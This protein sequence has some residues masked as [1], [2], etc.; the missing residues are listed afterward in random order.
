ML[1][2]QLADLFPSLRRTG[3]RGAAL[4]ERRTS[5]SSAG[6]DSEND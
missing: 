6:I 2:G 4:V 3:R 1:V 5:F